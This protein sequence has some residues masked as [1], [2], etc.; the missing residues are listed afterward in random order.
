MTEIALTLIF[1]WPATLQR[2]RIIDAST[3]ISCDARTD[4]RKTSAGTP[5]TISRPTCPLLAALRC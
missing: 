2:D 4:E 5:S 1:I 3:K